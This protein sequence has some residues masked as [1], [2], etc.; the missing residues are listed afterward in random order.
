[1]EGGKNWKND[2]LILGGLRIMMAGGGGK[3]GPKSADEINLRP[4]R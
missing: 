4:C 2:D 3:N 1:M